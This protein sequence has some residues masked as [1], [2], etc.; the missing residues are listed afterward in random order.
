MRFSNSFGVVWGGP[1][2]SSWAVRAVAT[3]MNNVSTWSH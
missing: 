3:G 2:M 1:G